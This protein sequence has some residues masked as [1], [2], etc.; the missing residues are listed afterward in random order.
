LAEDAIKKLGLLVAIGRKERSWSQVELADRVGTSHVTIIKIERGDPSVG[1]GSYFQAAVLA[2]VPL[3]DTAPGQ[4]LSTDQDQLRL[5]LLP[6]RI[7]RRE[8]GR[9]F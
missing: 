4:K 2:G 8:V 3:F 7:D 6:K 1:I 9:D 5:T